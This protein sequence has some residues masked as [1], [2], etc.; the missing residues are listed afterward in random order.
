[1]IASG[2]SENTTS[3]HSDKAPGQNPDLLVSEAALRA[4]SLTGALQMTL[5]G[6]PKQET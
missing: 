2:Y 4:R 1:M 5:K 6:I 3:R